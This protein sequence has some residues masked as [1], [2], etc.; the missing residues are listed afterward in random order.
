MALYKLGNR[1][2]DKMRAEHIA[3]RFRR[4]DGAAIGVKERMNWKNTYL[5]IGELEDYICSTT[6][7]KVSDTAPL[8]LADGM[9]QPWELLFLQPKRSLAE[10]RND[11]LCDITRY[12]AVNRPDPSFIG[13]ALGD[14][15]QTRRNC[16][17]CSKS[18][19]KQKK[20]A[21]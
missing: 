15:R 11:G 2:Q 1:L 6:P 8:P 18:T 17:H 9:V 7:T 16:H 10:E 3:L 19:A 5:H 4:A 14:A 21:R 12:M 13:Y 20:T